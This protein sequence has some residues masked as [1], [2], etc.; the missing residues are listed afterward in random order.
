[1][2]SN[3]A[4][5][6]THMKSNLTE[7][8]TVFQQHVIFEF[9]TDFEKHI[10]GGH[11]HYDSDYNLDSYSWIFLYSPLEAECIKPRYALFGIFG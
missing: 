10:I 9:P 8:E 11:R 4:G 3:N 2:N 1:M 7:I 6:N 5:I